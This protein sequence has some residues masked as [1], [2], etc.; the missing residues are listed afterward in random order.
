MLVSVSIFRHGQK[1]I[2]SQLE[3]TRGISKNC[4]DI[5]LLTLRKFC[6]LF[7]KLSETLF[8]F[9]KFNGLSNNSEI[10]EE[11]AVVD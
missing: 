5:F 11:L 8:Q 4:S 6:V 1:P 2:Q 9:E 10:C 7:I 3:N